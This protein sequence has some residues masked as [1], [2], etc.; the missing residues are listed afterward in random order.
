MVL[1]QQE[2]KHFWTHLPTSGLCIDTIAMLSDPLPE[3]VPFGSIEHMWHSTISSSGELLDGFT[4]DIQSSLED[5]SSVVRM[6][7]KYW[8]SLDQFSKHLQS[9][10]IKSPSTARLPKSSKSTD[11]SSKHSQS[12]NQLARNSPPTENPSLYFEPKKL[13]PFL[14]TIYI[15]DAYLQSLL[16]GRVSTTERLTR[17]D[18]QKFMSLNLPADTTDPERE[19][20]LA[21]VCNALE[22]GMTRRCMTVT[23]QGYIGAIP[24]ESQRGDLICVLFGCSVPVVLRKRIGGEYF[25]IGECYLHGFMDSEAIAFH[26]KGE[27]QVHKFI[28]C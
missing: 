25:F 22:A 16:C 20:F 6:Y 28:L 21:K 10:S 26:V 15:L 27:L 3:D 9:V 14:H 19:Y 5:I 17:D 12:T 1:D 7:S 11:L 23:K 18:I 24:Q 13:D 2:L 4:K 8:N